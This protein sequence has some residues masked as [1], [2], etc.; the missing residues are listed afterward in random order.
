MLK[1]TNRQEM[2]INSEYH[3]ICQTAKMKK[4]FII[5]ILPGLF[6]SRRHVNSYSYFEKQAYNSN[7][8]TL[9]SMGPLQRREKHQQIKI[10]IQECLQHHC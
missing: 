1:L 5:A 6:S 8:T 7:N 4:S 10:Y 2:Q 9:N 3:N